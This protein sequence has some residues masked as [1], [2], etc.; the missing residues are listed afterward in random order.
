MYRPEAALV[1]ARDS[2]GVPVSSS[3]APAIMAPM[4]EA[5]ELGP[6]LRV[7]EIGAGTGYNAAL[8]KRL[9]GENGRVVSVEV[10]PGIAARPGA[11]WPKGLTGPGWSW[12][13]EEKGGRRD[14]PMTGSSPQRARTSSQWR[15]ATSWQR[16]VWWSFPSGLA[17]ISV[18]KPSSAYDA[19]AKCS[20]RRPCSWAASCRLGHRARPLAQSW[21]SPR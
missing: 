11:T 16:A 8:I 12:A 1:T 19:T 14:P 6:G 15:G 20:G 17:R 13:R 21:P 9:V 4:L 7:L 18:P 10:D 2:T 3:S 5:L